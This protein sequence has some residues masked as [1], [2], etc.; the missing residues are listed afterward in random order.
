M[1][2]T[3]AT[4]FSYLWIRIW[5]LLAPLYLLVPP[6]PNYLCY[7]GGLTAIRYLTLDEKTMNAILRTV[8]SNT[9]PKGET[10]SKLV[11]SARQQP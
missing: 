2:S 4:D 1:G 7:R 8:S 10:G 9:A 11:A 5:V 6:L 3:T